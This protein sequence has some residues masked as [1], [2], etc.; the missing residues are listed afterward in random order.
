MD[1][2]RGGAAPWRATHIFIDVYEGR[3][4]EAPAAPCCALAGAHT[5]EGDAFPK[6]GGGGSTAGPVTVGG[7]HG[8]RVFWLTGRCSSFSQVNLVHL[9]WGLFRMGAEESTFFSSDRPAA[10]R[11]ERVMGPA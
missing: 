6:I 7:A 2:D 3:G 9:V 11:A 1:V 4:G 5:G 8:E 10:A